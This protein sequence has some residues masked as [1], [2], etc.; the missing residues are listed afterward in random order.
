[1]AKI[2]LFKKLETEKNRK[3]YLK[4]CFTPHK[5][6]IGIVATR[7]ARP[8]TAA[9]AATAT[10]G[11]TTATLGSQVWL[12]HPIPVLEQFISLIFSLLL[13]SQ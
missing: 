6:L 5:W 8:A 1:M 7:L 3:K 12:G 13:F 9:T 4:S 10:A 2:G 11:V